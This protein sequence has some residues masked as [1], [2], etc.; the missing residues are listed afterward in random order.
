MNMDTLTHQLMRELSGERLTQMSRQIGADEQTTSSA[1]TAVMPLLVSALA[2]NASQS[3]GAQSLHNALAEDHDGSI[4]NNLSAFLGNPQSANGAGILEH[5]LGG[6]QPVV[7]Q[8]LAEGSGL[9]RDQIQML[10]QIVAPLILGALGKQQQQQG[11]NPSDLSVFLGGQKEMDQQ[12]NPDLMSLLNN[13]LD[14]DRDG[15]A[16]DDIFRM[17]GRL[18]GRK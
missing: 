3:S 12:S 4:L 10:L 13:L 9:N 6:Q 1:L 14:R 15:S 11:F 7:T 5:V 18:F 2:N 16:L 8:G 17:L